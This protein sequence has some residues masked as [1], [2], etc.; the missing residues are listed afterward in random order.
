MKTIVV[1]ATALDYSGALTVLKQFVGAVPADGF[2][3]LV[4]I[5]NQVVLE[6][7]ATNVRLVPVAVKS[8]PKR[9]YWDAFGL[10]KWLKSHRISPV[11]A[12]SLQN[13]NFRVGSNIPNYI[14]FHQSILLFDHNWSPFKRKEKTLWFY[15]NIYPFFV[16]L[17]LNERSEIFVQIDYIRDEFAR[18]FNF[19]KE[20][21]HR[22]FPH[23]V[24]PSADQA[25]E[26]ELDQETINLIYPAT[27]FIYKNHS[28]LFDALSRIGDRRFVL[29]LTCEKEAFQADLS[30]IDVRFLGSL[31]FSKVLG[32]YA[33]ADALLF[34][35]YIETFGLPMIE[36][37]SFGIPVIASDLPYARQVLGHYAGV[38]YV[39]F[40]D[41]QA[42]ADKIRQVKKNR[43]YPA[44]QLADIP[45]WPE[46]FRIVTQNL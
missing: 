11:A 34:P 46:L 38:E 24:I 44:Y 16:R 36:A 31:P 10:K 3:Y 26:L 45:S 39:R 30:G 37:A 8:L 13:T 14:Y 4:F 27:P 29:Y 41:S 28:V 40:D 18:R 25:E 43:R 23:I 1:N 15:K 20:K 17:F 2:E 12:I 32:L 22:V 33:K 42:W 21:I 9:F 6:P 35:S 5:G 7:V 19:P